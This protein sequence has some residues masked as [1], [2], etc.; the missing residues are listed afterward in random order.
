[1]K[2][3]VA[4]KVRQVQVSGKFAA[5][6]ACMLGECWTNPALAEL[7]VTSDRFLMGRS[8]GDIGFNEFLGDVNDLH[9]NV[10]GLAK[11]ADLTPDE[12]RFLIGLIP[13]Y[14]G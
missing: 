8:E 2:K 3:D 11:V 4:D 6:L 10:M 13:S 7:T 1:M 12:T 9:R 5:I 14:D